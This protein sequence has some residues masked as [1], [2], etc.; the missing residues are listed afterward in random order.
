MLSIPIKQR[1][2][3]I[4][5]SV[6]T[7]DPCCCH[8]PVADIAGSIG[9]V[10]FNLAVKRALVDSAVQE[11]ESAPQLPELKYQSEAAAHIKR[12]VF[13]STTSAAG[14]WAAWLHGFRLYCCRTRAFHFCQL[15]VTTR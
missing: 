8:I 15:N 7:S 12:C 2:G 9:M 13:R 11:A 5:L 1:Y 10:E 14:F 3:A 6:A 4:G